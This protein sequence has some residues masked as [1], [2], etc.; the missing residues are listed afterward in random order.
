MGFHAPIKRKIIR[1]NNK[2][3]VT[4]NLRKEIMKRSHL[5]NIDANKTNNAEDIK[6]YK[7]QRNLVSKLNKAEK[8]SFFQNVDTSDPR[9][10]IWQKCAPYLSNKQKTT[11]KI[12]LVENDTI[13]LD[14]NENANIFN[15]YFC[16]IT[17]TL[18]IPKW[19]MPTQT[20]QNHIDPIKNAIWKYKSHPSIQQIKSKFGD[21]NKFSFQKVCST[22]C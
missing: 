9:M 22:S 11:E 10:T 16:N 4:K 5:K 13:K 20:Y 2:P 21:G 18:N 15:E 6:S 12:V 1:G 17:K 3:H 8:R 19:Q 14:D 7:I